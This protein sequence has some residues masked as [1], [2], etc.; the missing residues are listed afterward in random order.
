MKMRFS[1]LMFKFS[2]NVAS[3]SS[4][5]CWLNMRTSVRFC[6]AR[7]RAPAIFSWSGTTNLGHGDNV[8][9]SH[10]IWPFCLIITVLDW[11]RI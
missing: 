10:P 11:F 4:Y 7:Q 5:F 1:I 9:D 6:S 3:T 2:I 8:P